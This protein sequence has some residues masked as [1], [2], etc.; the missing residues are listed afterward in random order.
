MADTRSTTGFGEAFRIAAAVLLFLLAPLYVD[1]PKR[2][3]AGEHR[4][5]PGVASTLVVLCVSLTAIWY[6]IVEPFTGV[7][8]C[9]LSAVLIARRVLAASDVPPRMRYLGRAFTTGGIGRISMVEVL[10]GG[11]TVGLGVLAWLASLV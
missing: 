8:L 4:G 3:E 11:M 9:A 1:I 2:V 5:F 7:L 6:A 10:V